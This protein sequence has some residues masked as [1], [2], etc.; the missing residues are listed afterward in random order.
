MEIKMMMKPNLIQ[1]II[2]RRLN[3]GNAVP[4]LSPSRLLQG[5]KQLAFSFPA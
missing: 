2:E 5:G 3:S 1:E 4:N